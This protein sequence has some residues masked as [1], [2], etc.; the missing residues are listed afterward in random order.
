MAYF[1]AKVAAV[2]NLDWVEFY[3]LGNA[4]TD[5]YPWSIQ[6]T[7]G[8]WNADYCSM[9]DCEDAG[10]QILAGATATINYLMLFNCSVGGDTAMLTITATPYT[11]VIDHCIFMYHPTFGSNGVGIYLQDV[12]LTFTNN[13]LVGLRSSSSWGMLRIAEAAAVGTISDITIH[14]CNATYILGFTSIPTTPTTLSDFTIW[15]NAGAVLIGATVNNTTFNNFTIWGNTTQNIYIQGNNYNNTFNNLISDSET[16]YTTTNGIYFA[17]TQNIGAINLTINNGEFS[18]S[19]VGSKIAHTNDILISGQD[20]Q[21]TDIKLNNT[22]MGGTNE[23]ANN[24]YM[25]GGA[26][27]AAKYDQSTGATLVH[28]TWLRYGVIITDNDVFNTAAPS[29]KMTP[30]NASY[31]LESG[32]FKVN[33]NSGQTCTPSVYTRKSEAAE[34][35]SANY[36]GNHQ[37][38]ILKRNDAVG[39]TAD[40]VIDTAAG[41]IGNPWEQLTG[42]TAAATENGVMEFV[43]D[44]DGTTGFVS[45]DDFTATVA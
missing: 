17:L 38:L 35:D 45:V 34:G 23:V 7:T 43:V 31:K 25:I 9:Y 22:K 14:S 42:T 36:N 11:L 6:V 44:C 18:S 2:V 10:V 39:I 1:N 37:R 16:G 24:S 41:A 19:V 26:V 21:Y 3:Y 30:N 15:R 28:K 27:R 12:G 20:Y 13:T 32:S 4:S 29:M 8:S 40:T 5:Q 33:V